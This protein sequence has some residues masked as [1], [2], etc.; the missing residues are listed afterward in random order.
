MWKIPSW[1][2]FD[3]YW[4]YT[5][6]ESNPE[7]ESKDGQHIS[8]YES[9]RGSQWFAFR[10]GTR[11]MLERKLLFML[12]MFCDAR[13]ERRKLN[14]QRA[15]RW[16]AWTGRSTSTGGI[17]ARTPPSLPHA[18]SDPLHRDI[19]SLLAIRHLNRDSILHRDTRNHYL[20]IDSAFEVL[21]AHP[22]FE[23]LR[24]LARSVT[25]YFGGEE[26][27]EEDLVGRREGWASFAKGAERSGRGWRESAFMEL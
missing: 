19:L 10:R 13:L 24:A 17:K 23:K 3:L 9:I 26:E 11:R 27:V 7:A 14:C 15:W 2:G 18:E 25:G 21:C 8:A 12:S 1:E 4:R 6:D 20:E 5:W 22:E 16:I